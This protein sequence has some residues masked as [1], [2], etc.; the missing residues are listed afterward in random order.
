MDKP[1]LIEPYPGSTFD[2]AF[3]RRLATTVLAYW[4]GRDQMP[5][6]RLDHVPHSMGYVVRSDMLN[7]QPRNLSK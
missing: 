3:N 2:Y 5:E 4:I 7:G 6:V 1:R